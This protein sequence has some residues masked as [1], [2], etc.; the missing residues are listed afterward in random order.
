M[1]IW[2]KSTPFSPYTLMHT[3]IVFKKIVCASF[4]SVA[5]RAHLESPFRCFRAFRIYIYIH[6]GFNM[7][8]KALNGNVNDTTRLG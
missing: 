6:I 7:H 4:G 2:M 1:C 5:M 3:E 8:A